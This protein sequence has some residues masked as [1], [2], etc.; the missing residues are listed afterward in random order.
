[1]YATPPR[2][3]RRFPLLILSL[4]L[5]LAAW[6]GVQRGPAPEI[7]LRTDLPA[8]GPATAV[9]VEVREAKRGAPSFTVDALQ[10]Q[11]P[12]A[13]VRSDQP[14]PRP[15][16]ALWQSVSESATASLRLGSEHQESLKSGP[17][18][19]RVTTERAGTWLRSPA[20]VRQEFELTAQLT[21]PTVQLVSRNPGVRQGGAGAVVYEVGEGAVAHGVR[22]GEL[23]VAGYA[24]PGAD[25]EHFALYGVPYDLE[26]STDIQLF[27]VDEL[28]NRAE[29][30]FV[31]RFDRRP[32]K[33]DTIRLSDGFFENVVPEIQKNTPDLQLSGDLL[34]DYLTI[35]RDLR[36]QNAR[37]LSELRRRSK[38]ERLWTGPFL[39]LPSSR[40]MAGFAER[41]AYLYDGEA[42][43]EQTH[44]GHDLASVRQA[45]VPASNAGVV[46]LARYF[47]IYGETV[48]VD[49]G[50]GLFTLYSHL[51]SLAVA[52]GD[53]VE[54]GQN[55]G[56]T[57]VT[58]LSGGDHL[59]F[60]VMVGGVMVDPLEWWDRRWIETRITASL[61][62]AFE[63]A[64]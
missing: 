59:H 9:T 43:D 25:G 55:L 5:A 64:R 29:T 26:D 23:D 19:V 57:G 24:L 52:E 28:G 38:P 21:P 3:R 62:D 10:G 13:T 50:Y 56:R 8:I 7:T 14:T 1:M 42:V 45:P 20:T 61:G 33:V 22:V 51:S 53:A 46:V 2:R 6:T 39:Q 18:T 31:A 35:N 16:W 54:R 36:R 17:V 48:V 44:L 63:L 37:D 40:V 30:R 49:H 4:L 34:Q 27:A 41:R 15:P 12:L 11:T 47:G 60:S 32:A 58:G